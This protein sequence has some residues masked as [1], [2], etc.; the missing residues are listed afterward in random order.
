MFNF[1]AVEMSASKQRKTC[2]NS[3]MFVTL[4][5]GQFAAKLLV[6]CHCLALMTASLHYKLSPTHLPSV[7]MT[8]STNK[9]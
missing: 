1:M 5:T 6:G 8:T 4:T 9:P 2:V 7:S 3:F